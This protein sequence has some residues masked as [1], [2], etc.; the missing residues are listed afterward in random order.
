MKI[1][2]IGD[3]GETDYRKF[4]CKNVILYMLANILNVKLLTVVEMIQFQQNVQYVTIWIQDGKKEH[5]I[6]IKGEE[7]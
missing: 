6:M 7:K 2:R 1:I 5:I 3:K 4:K